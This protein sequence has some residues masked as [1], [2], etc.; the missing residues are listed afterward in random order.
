[1][2]GGVVYEGVCRAYVGGG[3]T[4]CVRPNVK[5]P[6]CVLMD[7]PVAISCGWVC[8]LRWFYAMYKQQNCL[9]L[10]HIMCLNLNHNLICLCNGYSNQIIYFKKELCYL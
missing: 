1:M 6:D 4:E 7:N 3:A 2:C 8:A 10:N 9:I 5:L